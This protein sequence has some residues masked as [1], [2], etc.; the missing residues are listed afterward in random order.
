MR[1]MLNFVI[2]MGMSTNT[3]ELVNYVV[4]SSNS[5]NY[6][7][8]SQTPSPISFPVLMENGVLVKYEIV[9]FSAEVIEQNSPLE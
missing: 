2:N 1:I 5:N 4:Q 9:K 3:K 7:A 8:N 6:E